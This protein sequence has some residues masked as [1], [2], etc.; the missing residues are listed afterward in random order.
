MI[1]SGLR[2]HL[3]ALAN[4]GTPQADD[5]G[6]YTDASEPLN[7]SSVYASIVPATGRELERHF[8]GTVIS[9]ATDIVTMPYHAGV[10]TKTVI[11]FN[12]RT[13]NVVGVANPEE[14]NIETICACVEVV[15]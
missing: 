14:R 3:I 15:A 5:D 4:P 8:A 13:L 10:T 12:T 7:P 2:R 1:A 6:G 11:T 9:M